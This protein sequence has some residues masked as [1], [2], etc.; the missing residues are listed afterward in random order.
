MAN[1]S[2]RQKR[3]R[4]VSNKPKKPKKPR[5]SLQHGEAFP[6]GRVSDED[7]VKYHQLKQGFLNKGKSE[8]QAAYF[9][10][11]MIKGFPDY[12]Q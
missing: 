11:G 10:T 12:W 8:K 1:T 3:K 9:A 5:P 6:R 4:A 2:G 7:W